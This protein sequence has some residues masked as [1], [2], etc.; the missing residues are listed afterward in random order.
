MT[1]FRM[2]ERD[3]DLFL[4]EEL[5][6]DT[7]FSDWL[8]EQLGLEGFTFA[9]ATHSVSAKANAKWGET[10]VLAFFLKS[11][12]R[13]AVL[14]EDKIS[15]SFTERQA[16]RYHERA[17]E[18]VR[19]GEAD[20]YLTVLI[21]P[22][23]YLAGVPKDDPW[24]KMLSVE[25]LRD[26]FAGH[27]DTHS[28]WRKEALNDCLSRIRASLSAKQEDIVRFGEEFSTYLKQH[29]SPTL[30]HKPGKD[31]AGPIIHYPKA[32]KKRMIWWKVQTSQMTAQLADD[33][34]G[35]IAHLELPEGIGRELAEDFK[36]KSDYLVI[37]VPPVDFSIPPEE[38][39]DVVE[40][41]LAAAYRLIAFL[42]EIDVA[43]Q[44]NPAI[45]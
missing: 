30:S 12:E 38:Q 44:T 28:R 21:A 2:Q 9:R 31:S 23:S 13:I 45:N 16:Q 4:L 43:T 22:Q 29:H 35:L 10:D 11:K 32:T 5:H 36:R 27:D 41:A 42:P 37:D 8:A 40:A 25:A 34:V 24:Q 15:A 39:K 6:S 19:N 7:G 1:H 20:R 17:K 33:M 18:Y 26:W 3:L 14:I